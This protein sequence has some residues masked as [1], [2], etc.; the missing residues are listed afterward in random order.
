MKL[1]FSTT[2]RRP[3]RALVGAMFLMGAAYSLTV[4]AAPA[5]A[6]GASAP[7][8]A[9]PAAASGA[10]GYQ[11]PTWTT[12]YSDIDAIRA[13]TE[14]AQAE[15]DNL[16][17]HHKLEQARVG[18]FSA[19]GNGTPTPGMSSLPSLPAVSSPVQSAATAQAPRDP[20][21]E[22]VS[23]VDGQWTALIRLS[24]GARVNVHQGQSVHGI[25]KIAAI[26]LNQVIATDGGKSTAL[27]FAGDTSQETTT[28]SPSSASRMPTMPFGLH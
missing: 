9:A 17:I 1:H 24:S 22:Q 6:D 28:A 18:N 8:A 23:M 10:R 26:S 7:A 20:Q 25:G 5:D 11:T 13:D 19:D 16:T 4:M 3:I 15:L 2:L 12:Y 14:K 21:V 27:A